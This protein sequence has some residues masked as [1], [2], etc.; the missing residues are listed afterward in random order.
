MKALQGDIDN[1]KAQVHSKETHLENLN[2]D[3]Q[4]LSEKLNE[5]RAAL[6]EERTACNNKERE[7]KELA[8]K[9][10]NKLA[11]FGP[12][13]VEFVA[14]LKKQEK[15]FKKMPI[16]PFGNLMQ[17]KKNVTKEQARAV[18][19]NLWAAFAGFIV[20]NF[21]DKLIFDNIQKARKTNFP[22]I[23]SEF[24]SQVYDI[25]RGRCH[26]QYPTIYD[27]LEFG[28]VNVA[29]CLIDQKKIDMILVVPKDEDAQRLLSKVDSV[30]KNCHFAI[31]TKLSQ[32]YPAPTYRSYPMN[33]PR[34]QI[35]GSN[36]SDL[37]KSLEQEWKARKESLEIV[38]DQLND[39]NDQM[40]QTKKAINEDMRI[41]GQLK[42]AQ[43]SKTSE[44]SR[45]KSEEEN[46]APPDVE[47]LQED[48]DSIK[49][50]VEKLKEV[51][52]GLSNEYSSA[53]QDVQAAKEE[54]ERSQNKEKALQDKIDPLRQS[55]LDL[56]I[57]AEKSERL[58][59]S[60]IEKKEGYLGQLREAKL[61]EAQ[62]HQLLDKL[63]AKVEGEERI[64][65]NK[66]PEILSKEIANIKQRLDADNSGQ[67]SWAMVKKELAESQ[68]H[69]STVKNL[70]TEMTST[71][72]KLIETLEGRG[73][74][75]LRIKSL[76]T[77]RINNAFGSYLNVRRYVGSVVINHNT[78]SLE[79]IVS[80]EGKD[81]RRPITTLS[82]GEKSYSTISFLLALW[83]CIEPP[84]RILDEFDVFMD[85]LNRRMA[86][87]QIMKYAKNSKQF[88]YIFLT[89]LGTDCI[90]VGED[91]SIVRLEKNQ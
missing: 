82:G 19:A 63:L 9:R 26:S 90:E 33:P 22:L 43:R 8:K 17:L 31:T 67:E 11:V 44:I 46:E 85:M 16:G 29:N 39:I 28:D 45:L 68:K 6:S 4:N 79:I 84:F 24:A 21:Q 32:Y 64:Q 10:N 2:N 42:T 7:L 75:F 14:E 83:D 23:V 41:V 53:T 20:D 40:S 59:H 27:L 57:E 78:K 91:V 54:L 87:E 65:T 73:A 74:A 89:P 58:K 61:G 38:N 72:N 52:E 5:A 55:L 80:P 60:F 1:L 36:V 88:Q 81:D 25:S 30:P 47:A 3:K 34:S 49:V 50:E 18:E 37:I 15:T 56:G 35:L 51:L 86:L 69:Y 62:E 12:S 71:I 13:M 76:T 66:R 48:Y 77:F 70:V